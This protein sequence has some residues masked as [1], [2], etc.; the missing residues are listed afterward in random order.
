MYLKK[1]DNLKKSYR[2]FKKRR[3]L[4][5]CLCNLLIPKYIFKDF[6]KQMYNNAVR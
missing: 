3:F 2:D 4:K 5:L 1:N 6:F